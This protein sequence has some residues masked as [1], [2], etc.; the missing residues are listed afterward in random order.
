L[1]MPRLAPL[2]ERC[3]RTR[4]ARHRL[5]WS[6]SR[7]PHAEARRR[8]PRWLC[9]AKFQRRGHKEAQGF[10]SAL[11][12]PFAKPLPRKGDTQGT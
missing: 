9:L 3:G 2:P 10:L 6:Q 5:A 12:Y 7:V 8:A 1:V 11:E 4:Q